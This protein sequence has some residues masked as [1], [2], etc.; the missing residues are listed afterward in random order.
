VYET[1]KPL[2]ITTIKDANKI[3]SGNY[4][5]PLLIDDDVNELLT[6]FKFNSNFNFYFLSTFLVTTIL[7]ISFP[8]TIKLGI[9][10]II[11]FYLINIPLISLAFYNQFKF[12]SETKRI[13]AKLLIERPLVLIPDGCRKK[14]VVNS[15]KPWLG[16]FTCSLL[17]EA[18]NVSDC[19]KLK[20]T[21]NIME[22]ASQS[23]PLIKK[24]NLKP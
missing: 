21:H 15:M 1:D 23:I 20:L 9:N 24:H 12:M 8:I 2:F 16:A 6:A 19:D 22:F 13:G 3:N 10:P 14:S 17:S 7:I 11:F 4:F 18:I 5:S